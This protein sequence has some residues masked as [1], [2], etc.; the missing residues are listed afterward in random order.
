MESLSAGDL[1][2]VTT[3]GPS[4]DGIVVDTLTGS[5]AIVAL[6]DPV[7]GPVLRTVSR[8]AL[9][10]R[11]EAGPDDRALQLLI[12]RTPAHRRGATRGGANGGTGGGGGYTRAAPHRAT[13]K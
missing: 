7:R 9:A 3:G 4:T 8:K 13:G 6:R 5:K 1:V 2:K 12:R 10:E 11:T